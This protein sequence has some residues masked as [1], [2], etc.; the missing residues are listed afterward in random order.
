MRIPQKVGVSVHTIYIT[1]TL[2]PIPPPVFL[3]LSSPPPPN[4]EVENSVA[5]RRVIQGERI[6]SQ[7][8]KRNVLAFVSFQVE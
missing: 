7:M 6:S 5:A 4:Y 8:H 2:P 1:N 3:F